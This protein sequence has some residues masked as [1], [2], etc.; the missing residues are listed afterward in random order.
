MV[1][2]NSIKGLGSAELSPLLNGIL[3]KLS[4]DNIVLLLLGGLLAGT[5]CYVSNNGGSLEISHGDTIV[6]DKIFFT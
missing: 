6:N 1:N 4:G 3:A 2:G 5:L